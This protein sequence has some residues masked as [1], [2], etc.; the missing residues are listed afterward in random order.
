MNALD[1]QTIEISDPG[2]GLVQLVVDAKTGLPSK[3]LYRVPNVGTGATVSAEDDL[4]DF[5]DVAGIQ[6]PYKITEIRNG[7]K[8]SD[9]TVTEIKLN[10]GLKVPDLSKRP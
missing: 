9:V 7:E 5:R 8:F 1:G 10:S 6:L 3:L 2:A 4:D